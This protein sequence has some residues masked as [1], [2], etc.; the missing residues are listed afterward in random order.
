[1]IPH[2]IVVAWLGMVG[3]VVLTIAQGIYLWHLHM[4]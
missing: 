3:L 2:E 4:G 1:M